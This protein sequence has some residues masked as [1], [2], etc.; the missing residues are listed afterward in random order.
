MPKEP[1]QKA[2]NV[3]IEFWFVTALMA[4]SFILSIISAVWP[5]LQ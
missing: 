1:D 4:R 3:E 2:R 5:L